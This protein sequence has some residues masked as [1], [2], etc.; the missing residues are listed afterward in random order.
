[1]PNGLAFQNQL[2]ITIQSK[3]YNNK[4]KKIKLDILNVVTFIYQLKQ[5]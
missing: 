4:K 3:L 2:I 1:M 5:K